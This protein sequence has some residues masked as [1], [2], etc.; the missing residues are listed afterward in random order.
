MGLAR[1]LNCVKSSG[2]RSLLLPYIKKPFVYDF[3]S[4]SAM[5]SFVRVESLCRDACLSSSGK[6]GMKKRYCLGGSVLSARC[7]LRPNFVEMYCLLDVWDD[8]NL[9]CSGF[10]WIF[11][12]FNPYTHMYP[13]ML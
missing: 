4:L 11:F 9:L 2:G 5:A 6:S 8:P 12:Y 7:K 1:W 3:V 10:Y 13:D